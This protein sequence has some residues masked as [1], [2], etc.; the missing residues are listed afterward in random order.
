MSCPLAL[1]KTPGNADLSPDWDN[2]ITQTHQV[3]VELP[4]LFHSS[5]MRDAQR[6]ASK[7]GSLRSA[8]EALKAVA[9]REKINE[10]DDEKPT[11]IAD[12]NQDTANSK[13]ITISLVQIDD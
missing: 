9:S 2:A 1:T 5:P 6:A 11:D 7:N 12:L 4:E 3:M 10:S 13:R 8:A